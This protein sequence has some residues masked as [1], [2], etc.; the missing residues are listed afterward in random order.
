MYESKKSSNFIRDFCTL[1]I[2]RMLVIEPKD[3]DNQEQNGKLPATSEN[4]SHRIRTSDLVGELQKLVK[5]DPNYYNP[6]VCTAPLN[7]DRRRYCII[8]KKTIS[9]MRG[10]A[11][12]RR[13]CETPNF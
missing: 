2:N 4:Q 11:A 6:S 7:L 1:I 5:D 12:E 10:E 13:K 9:Q 3:L 8:I